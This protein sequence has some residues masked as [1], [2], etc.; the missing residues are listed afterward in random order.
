MEHTC[1]LFQSRGKRKPSALKAV[2]LCIPG[3]WSS[4]TVHYRKR[5]TNKRLGKN[6]SITTIDTTIYLTG[7]LD[8]FLE[9]LR[10]RRAGKRLQLASSFNIGLDEILRLDL[11][12]AAANLVTPE[13]GSKSNV[14]KGGLT[15]LVVSLKSPKISV[16]ASERDSNSLIIRF[17]R[18][19]EKTFQKITSRIEQ[20]LNAL[21]QHIKE[22]FANFSYRGLQLKAAGFFDRTNFKTHTLE[23]KGLSCVSSAKAQLQRLFKFW[24][25]T[26]SQ[27]KEIV[28]FG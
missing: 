21:C 23:D 28:L 27:Q 17:N 3:I 7:F 18:W 25:S 13:A 10:C 20:K 9:L 5:D 1:K 14:A 22:E 11:D 24:L 6:S 12:L 4:I 26:L 8:C 19:P 15:L 2:A 16:P